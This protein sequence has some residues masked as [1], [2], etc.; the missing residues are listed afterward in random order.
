MYRVAGWWV[1]YLDRN[2][3]RMGVER[4]NDFHEYK[5]IGGWT[6]VADGR[7]ED[8]EALADLWNGRGTN[9]FNYGGLTNVS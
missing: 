4:E 3:K 1:L 7:C 8:M 2:T 9:F 5:R 6:H